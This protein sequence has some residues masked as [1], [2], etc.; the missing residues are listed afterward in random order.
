MT[1]AQS[2][3]CA[4]LLL[5]AATLAGCASKPPIQFYALSADP[6]PAASAAANRELVLAIGPVDLPDY[7]RR[8]QIVTRPGANRLQVDE[9]NR[10]GGALEEEIT[11][12]V[13][14]HLGAAL[15]TGRVYAYPSRVVPDTDLRI[16]LSFRSF[17]GALGDAVALEAAW[18][19][20]DERSARVLATSQAVYRAPVAGAGYVDYAAALSAGLALLS[21]DLAAAVAAQAGRLPPPGR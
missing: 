18:S 6:A 10:W 21:S 17:D 15:G 9:F 12:V 1:P 8:P 16:A 19:V 13:A 5:L 4:A 14:R 3:R 2:A 20:I 7:L 11:R